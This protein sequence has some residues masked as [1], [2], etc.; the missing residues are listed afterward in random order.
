[1]KNPTTEGTDA[2]VPE[3]DLRIAKLSVE[4]VKRIRN[5]S[6]VPASIG[7]TKIGGNNRQG[8]TSVLDA[9]AHALCGPEAVALG[10]NLINDDAEEIPGSHKAKARTIVEFS[11]GT[12]VERRLTEKNSRTGLL[13]ITLPQGQEGT[14]DDLKN[15]I[16]KVALVPTNMDA[17]TERERLKHLLG[18]VKVDLSDLEEMLDDVTKEKESLY[19]QKELAQKHAND[20]PSWEGCPTTEVK[21]SDIM[22]EL[23]KA[24]DANAANRAKKQ[25]VEK[26]ETV[27][28][29]MADTAKRKVE[30][31][32]ELRQQLKVAEEDAD[33][34]SK[35]AYEADEAFKTAQSATAGLVDIPTDELQKKLEDT[36]E[37]N[38]K[39]RDNQTKEQR[40][41]D[42]AELRERWNGKSLEQED[43]LRDMKSRVESADIPIPGLGIDEQL[44]VT[45]DNQIWSD[46]SGMQ[47]KVTEAAI[48]SLYQP[49]ASF[50]LADGLEALDE[51]SQARFHKWA[52]SR[53]LQII[54]TEVRGSYAGEKGDD[55]VVRF[56]ISDGMV[57]E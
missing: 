39:V 15:C 46:C 54:G 29:A 35:A 4:G 43:V 41:N 36:D 52:I 16:S 44:R 6:I 25:E 23:Q 49:H 11:D 12:R 47:K 53:G 14:L 30:R 8:K 34:A 57:Q 38:K 42:A 31:I 13:T 5:V 24:M 28:R 50:I 51:Q 48:A 45:F 3:E 55:G 9:L 1:M 19:Q 2:Y 56:V 20:L 33:L 7:L 37:L 26:L 40:N 32:A 22:A 21:A 17:M 18:G 27:A 10:A